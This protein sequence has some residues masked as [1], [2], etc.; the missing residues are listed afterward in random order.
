MSVAVR[1]STGSLIVEMMKQEV[2]V[3]LEL[4]MLVLRFWLMEFLLFES[5]NSYTFTI[6]IIA[7][8]FHFEYRA[9]PHQVAPGDIHAGSLF[10]GEL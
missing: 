3:K 9:I 5:K 10:P 2:D 6:Y 7:K 4:T 8:R 1:E